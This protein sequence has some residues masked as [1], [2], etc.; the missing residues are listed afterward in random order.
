[1]SGPLK[2]T[3]DSLLALLLHEKNS[4]KQPTMNQEVGPHRT[5]NLPA[6]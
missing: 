5:L 2:E 1:M 6:P 3:S 4:G